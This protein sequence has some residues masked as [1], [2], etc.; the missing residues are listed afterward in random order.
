MDTREIKHIVALSRHLKFTSAADDLGITQ[1]A[2]SKSIQGIEERLQIRLFDRNRGGVRPT[3]M[4]RDMVRKAT[5]ILAEMRELDRFAREASGGEVGKVSFGMTPVPAKALLS[6]IMLRLIQ[7][8]P[9]LSCQVA[10]R[11]ADV[12]LEALIAEEVEFYIGGEHIF[13]K[14][15]AIERKLLGLFPAALMV[16]S[17]HPLLAYGPED[18]PVRVKDYPLLFTGPLPTSFAHPNVEA[19]RR[20]SVHYAVEGLGTLASLVEKSDA[21]L[22]GSPFSA[23]EGLEHGRLQILPL[24]LP[25]PCIRIMIH[26]LAH[27]SLSPAAKRI[28]REAKQEVDRLIRRAGSNL[29]KSGNLA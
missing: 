8:T 24:S 22:L 3:A 29:A 2:L 9:K 16:R 15:E 12:M 17:G 7:D 26:T 4:G 6:A 13:A 27:R 20:H 11:T 21:I 18:L 23:G 14:D 5:S 19:V 28:I 25:Q 10:V 1:S